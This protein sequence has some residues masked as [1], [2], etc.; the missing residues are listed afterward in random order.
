MTSTAMEMLL[1]GPIF[2]KVP[3][4]RKGFD[5]P[6]RIRRF[7]WM[8]V[9]AVVVVLLTFTVSLIAV[10]HKPAAVFLG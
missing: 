2:G 7:T 9:A 10:L 4:I 3:T 8:D 6:N 5:F 1:W